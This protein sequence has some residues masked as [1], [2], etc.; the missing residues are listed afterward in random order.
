MYHHTLNENG[1]Y[2]SRC[3]HCFMT[4][5]SAVDTELTLQDIEALHLCPEK[6]LA[7]LLAGKNAA[8][9]AFEVN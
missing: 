6:V 5:A 8:Q 2:N 9:T 7:D 3:L 4:I 1:T